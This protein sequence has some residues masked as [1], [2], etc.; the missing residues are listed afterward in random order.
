MV[1]TSE[2][3]EKINWHFSM[4]SGGQDRRV[5]PIDQV[6]NSFSPF[7][8]GADGWIKAIWVSGLGHSYVIITL[9]A[10][11]LWPHLVNIDLFKQSKSYASKQL[12]PL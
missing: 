4:Q 3:G 7:C 8:Q 6:R 10:T 9:L 5:D 1:V 12:F 2:I 11:F